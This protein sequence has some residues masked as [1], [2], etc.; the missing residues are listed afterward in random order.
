M[1]W[2]LS[3]ICAEGT[4][5]PGPV[6]VMASFVDLLSSRDFYHHASASLSIFLLGWFIGMIFGVVAGVLLGISKI[7][8]QLGLPWMA[9]LFPIPKIAFL[10]VF[11]ILLGVG[12][13]ARI[14]T[15]ASGVFFPAVFCILQGTR[16]VPS[17]LI[18]MGTVFGLTRVQLLYRIVIPH[19]LPS[20][21]LACRLTTAIALIL[22][23][24]AEMIG[25]NYGIG[26]FILGAGSMALMDQLFAGVLVLSLFGSMLFGLWAV[27]E[28]K[29]LHWQK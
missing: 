10:P 7:A 21:F 27:L 9:L 28:K 1:A 26:A 16:S 11:I 22:L 4:L 18:E 23:V 2:E 13:G 20:L 8:Y 6:A 5:I 17:N 24:S 29:V 12:E 15:I 14:A 25:A 3:I 19:C